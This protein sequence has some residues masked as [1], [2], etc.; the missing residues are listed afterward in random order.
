MLLS[1]PTAYIPE[2]EFKIS[3]NLEEN[4]EYIRKKFDIPK[5]NDIVV[6]N[7]MLKGNRKGWRNIPRYYRQR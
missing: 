1:E 6:R 5:N 3:R 2:K 4:I 7:I